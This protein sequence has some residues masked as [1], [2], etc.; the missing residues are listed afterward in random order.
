[1]VARIV[2][3]KSIRGMLVY[4]EQ[5]IES[6]EAAI[7]LAN[8][9]ATDINNLNLHQKLYRFQQLT[10]LNTRSKTNAMHVSLSFHKDDNLDAFKL[11]QISSEYM[12]RIGLGDQPFIVYS[13][14]DTAHPHIHIASTLIQK[15]GNRIKTEGIGRSKSEPAR[16]Y[17]EKKYD[18]IEAKGRRLEDTH[19]LRVA[20]YGASSTK[21]QI[22]N[23]TKSVM[24]DYAYTSFAEYKAVLSIYRINADRGKEDTNM[25]KNNGLIYSILDKDGLKVGVPFKSSSFFNGAT[26]RALEKH[27]QPNIEKRK[28]SRADL[29]RRIDGVKE[30]YVTLTKLLFQRE[31]A[32]S[33]IAVIYRENAAGMIYGMTFIDHKNRTVF[34]GSDLGKEFSAKA[35]T[36]MLSDIDQLK[37]YLK[38][39]LISR[40]GEEPKIDQSPGS[41][42]LLQSLLINDELEPIGL[43]G[44]RKKKKKGKQKSNDLGL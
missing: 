23:I 42:D 15:N 37:S 33:Q 1:M 26:M 41:G 3:G 36:E 16:I 40:F 6:G 17:L 28:S 39:S 24:Q 19:Y 14:F 4:N 29:Q 5:K 32:S 8:G 21:R 43:L 20:E 34:N 11:Q 35:I 2:S 13:H 25:F 44:K 31:L 18:L 12:E 30:K 7:L 10:K 9:F 38:S 27:Y 22:G